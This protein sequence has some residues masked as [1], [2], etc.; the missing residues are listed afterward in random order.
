[1]A[2]ARELLV[3]TAGPDAARAA[4]RRRAGTSFD[5]DV[6]DAACIDLARLRADPD[7]DLNPSEV[8]G[9]EPEPRL[10]Y[11]GEALD[12]VL[13]A[14]GAVADLK[15]GYTRAHSAGVAARA[16]SAA[17]AVGCTDAEVRLVRRAGW[18]H[19]IG[20]VAVSSRVWDRPGPLTDA[21]W[22]KV[23][24]HPYITER[25]LARCPGLAEVAAVAGGHHERAD[26]SGYH[27]GVRQLDRL[28]ALLAAAD[29]YQSTG[30]RRPYRPALG[31]SERAGVL[32]AQAL[33]DWAVDAVLATG[34]HPTGPRPPDPLT[35]REREVLALVAQGA[36][37]REAAQ[38]LRI[39]AKTVN[40]HLEHIFAKLGVT[41]RGAA[42][43][44]AMELG[45]LG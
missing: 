32:R 42:A 40:A 6:V 26:G 11:T 36:T 24:L 25:V 8:L 45:L 23:R 10:Q 9:G 38:R 34:G 14:I 27:R 31:P 7:D 16:A 37:N 39:S 29:V 13:A 41:T 20:R 35:A 22:D 30:E 33:P 12:R 17:E 44:Q 21:Q 19:D 4:L 2:N 43:Y 3:R 1:V 5:P 28:T 18:L 15:S